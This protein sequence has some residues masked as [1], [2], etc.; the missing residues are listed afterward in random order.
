[1]ILAVFLIASGVGLVGAMLGIGGGVFLV[2]ILTVFL[3]VPIKVA[4]GASIV[5]VIATSS[6]GGTVYIGHGL[7]H[8]RL[9]MVLEV[10]TT[11]GALTGGLTAVL[12][13]PRLLEGLFGLVLFYVLY[14]MQRL[15]KEEPESSPTGL[16]DNSYLNPLTG[17][18]II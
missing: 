9:A 16:L 7:A 3:G 12:I 10:A 18:A 6:A 5:S 15:P 8:T 13:S 1:L 11:L 2:P 4:I 14:N 17:Q